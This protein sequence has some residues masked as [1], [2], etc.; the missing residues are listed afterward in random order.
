MPEI[1][2]TR[3]GKLNEVESMAGSWY[4]LV[5]KSRHEKV[6]EHILA[7]KG[8]D[9]FLPLYS[10]EHRYGSRRREYRLPLFPGYLFCRFRPERLM[11]ILNTPAVVQIVGVGKTPAAID[12]KEMDSL[13]IAADSAATLSPHPWPAPGAAVKVISGPLNGVEGTVVEMKEFFRI[14]LS[15]TMLQRSVAVEVDRKQVAMS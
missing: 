9:T 7:N 10:R 2:F 8:F 4:A 13:R 12:E 15:I 11:P 6:A 14:V 1:G 5:V 3:N